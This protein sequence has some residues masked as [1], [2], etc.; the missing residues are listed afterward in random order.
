MQR[1]RSV[2]S[3]RVSEEIRA[4]LRS[5]GSGG[6]VRL[7][8]ALR[9]CL[10]EMERLDRSYSELTTLRMRAERVRALARAGRRA[11]ADPGGYL[12]QISRVLE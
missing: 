5:Y 12:E 11:E 8:N 2:V 7:T 1:G 3:A 6:D 10:D 9:R 4:L